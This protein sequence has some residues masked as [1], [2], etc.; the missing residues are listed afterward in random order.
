MCSLCIF[1]L[2]LKIRNMLHRSLFCSNC[3]S[4]ACVA[5]VID[6]MDQSWRTMEA[7]TCS[8][9]IFCTYCDELYRKYIEWETTAQMDRVVCL[10]CGSQRTIL[11]GS[12]GVETRLSEMGDPYGADQVADYLVP[13]PEVGHPNVCGLGHPFTRQLF[14]CFAESRR[15]ECWEITDDHVSCM[16][17]MVHFHNVKRW[18]HM[19]S[20]GHVTVE[21]G[22]GTA[23]G[24]ADSSIS[25]A[26]S[27]RAEP[28]VKKLRTVHIP[29]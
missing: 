24:T 3:S 9:R 19:T 29:E 22:G 8:Y 23:D 18:N 12:I 28:E 6:A 20:S 11:D 14:E 15:S 4:V 7:D 5:V 10:V 16:L 25:V 21:F 1:A 17:R 2:R 27:P 26:S 13:L